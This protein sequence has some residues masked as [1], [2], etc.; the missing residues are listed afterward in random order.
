MEERK[1]WKVVYT[2]NNKNCKLAFIASGWP[3]TFCGYYGYKTAII[4]EITCS[5]KNCPFK[6]KRNFKLRRKIDNEG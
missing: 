2:T 4:R 5:Y 3:E 1:L 6:I